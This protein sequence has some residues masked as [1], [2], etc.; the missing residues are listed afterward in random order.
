MIKNLLNSIYKDAAILN[1]RTGDFK[2]V[3]HS[4]LQTMLSLRYDISNK[5]IFVVLPNLYEAQKYYDTLSSTI[6][7]SKVLFYPMDQTLT[8]MMA[9]GS[10]GFKNERLFF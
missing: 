4:Y 1:A 9:L 10:P 6:D 8:S 3:S 7:E 5:N 2:G